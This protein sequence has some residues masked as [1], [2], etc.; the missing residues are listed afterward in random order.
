M[1]DQARSAG[2]KLWL[3]AAPARGATVVAQLPICPSER[4]AP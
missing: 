3:R 2:G 4:G 1:K